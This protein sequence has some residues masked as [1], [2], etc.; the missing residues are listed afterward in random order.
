MALLLTLIG[1]LVA[2]AAQGALVLFL[3]NLGPLGIDHGEP[4]NV[5]A[6]LAINISLLLFF[7]APHSLMARPR[8]KQWWTQLVSH[9]VERGVYMLMS[10]LT[11]ATVVHFW[12]PLPQD[13]WSFSSELVRWALFA[14]FGLGLGIV[15]WAIFAVDFFHFHGFRQATTD[16]A[17]EPPFTVRG[18]YRFARHPIQTGLIIALWSTP[19]MTLGHLLFAA[20]MTAYSLIATLML[21]E[22]DL[23]KAL[24]DDYQAYARRV[25]AIVPGFLIPGR[26]SR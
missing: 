10:G 18:P 8:F 19:D 26:R 25:P 24:G 12:S 22:R 17:V 11:L 6:A 14:S 3:L 5:V 21:E 9:K 1:V 15:F 4:I 20:G 23:H 2:L 13:I 7:G 16:N